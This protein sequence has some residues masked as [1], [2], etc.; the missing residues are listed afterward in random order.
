MLAG[1]WM[2]VVYG[3]GG[4]R[5]VEDTLSFQ[6]FIPDSWKQYSFKILFRGHRFQITVKK[7]TVKITQEEGDSCKILVHGASYNVGEK[8]T[9]TIPLPI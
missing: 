1:T 3:F 5:I 2:S 4:M 8:E 7:E 9:I 6:P